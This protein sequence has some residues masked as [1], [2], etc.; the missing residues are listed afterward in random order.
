[1]TKHIIIT[2]MTTRNPVWLFEYLNFLVHLGA[3]DEFFCFFFFSTTV[4]L[5]LPPRVKYKYFKYF[6]IRHW[7]E[8][9]II[10]IDRGAVFRGDT[11]IFGVFDKRTAV[12][13]I[14]STAIEFRKISLDVVRKYRKT[15]LLKIVTEMAQRR[16][17]TSDTFSR[18]VW[19]SQ[20]WQLTTFPVFFKFF[21]LTWNSI[22]IQYFNLKYNRREYR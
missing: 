11:G 20:L 18:T 7:Y 16:N 12:Y 3:P 21:L 15:G 2:A 10:I 8:R 17:K 1:M 6:Y 5:H 4:N 19:K 13:M 14:L 9:S 22:C